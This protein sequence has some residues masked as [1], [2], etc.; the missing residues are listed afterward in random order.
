MNDLSTKRE[1]RKKMS[2]VDPTEFGK[3]INAVDTLE[4]NV[5]RLSTDVQ[6]LTTQ[7]ASSKG[8]GIGIMIAASGLGAGASKLMD[9]LTK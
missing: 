2:D 4:K 7:L 8:I 9:M 3:L 6:A 1:R 5:E